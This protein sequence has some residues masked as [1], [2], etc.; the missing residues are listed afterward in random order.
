MFSVQC[1][2]S[3]LSTL[4]QVQLL[5]HS[6][7]VASAVSE[8]SEGFQGLGSWGLVFNGPAHLVVLRRPFAEKTCSFRHPYRA[9][10]IESSRIRSVTDL[11]NHLPLRARLI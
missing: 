4:Y 8:K 1:I 5:A 2:S 9:H 7:L 11:I 10:A 3:I 6:A